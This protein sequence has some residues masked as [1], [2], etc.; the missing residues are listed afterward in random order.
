MEGP[1]T[2]VL[3]SEFHQT[4]LRQHGK[5]NHT[6]TSTR[7]IFV[8]SSPTQLDWISVLD[9]LDQPRVSASCIIAADTD[10]CCKTTASETRQPHGDG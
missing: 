2:F 1:C 7:G 8:F 10:I 3:L 5:Y 4:A 6:E 9:S